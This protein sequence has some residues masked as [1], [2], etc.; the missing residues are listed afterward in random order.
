MSAPGCNFSPGPVLYKV[1]IIFGAE[2]AVDTW[3]PK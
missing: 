2:K 1:G 3:S